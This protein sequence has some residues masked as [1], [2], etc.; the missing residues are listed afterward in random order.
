[1]G[2]GVLVVC[3]GGS[4]GGGGVDEDGCRGG[5]VVGGN[6]LLTI[7][8]VLTMCSCLQWQASLLEEDEGIEI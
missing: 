6:V 1:M 5:W 4:G 8:P 2:V 7:A 3:V